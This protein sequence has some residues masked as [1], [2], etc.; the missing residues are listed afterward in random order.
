[1]RLPLILSLLILGIA[2]CL[3]PVASSQGLALESDAG[4]DAGTKDADTE[5]PQHCTYFNS[6]KDSPGPCP[7]GPQERCLA[8]MPDVTQASLWGCYGLPPHHDECV[9]QSVCTP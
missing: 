3:D 7:G 9:A 6:T 5:A 8:A 4:A 1:M 2:G